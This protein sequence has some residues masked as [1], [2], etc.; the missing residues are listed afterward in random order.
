MANSK[1]FT[2]IKDFLL[3]QG[4]VEGTN[5]YGD[6]TFTKTFSIP[7]RQLVVNGK[8]FDE[9]AH[10]R[11]FIITSLGPGTM[12]NVGEEEEEI[13][14]FNMANNDLWVFSLE[15]FRFWYDQIFKY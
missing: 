8:R 14:G 9:P 2:F 15:D 7:G 4:F 11:D 1:I 6:P 10:N 12:Y 13:W 3:N 5:S